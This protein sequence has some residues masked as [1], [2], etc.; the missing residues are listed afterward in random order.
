MAYIAG[1]FDGEGS[2][3]FVW[4]KA[5]NGK[6]YG[7]LFAKIAQN[8]RR[9]LDWVRRVLG[10]GAVYA[11]KPRYKSKTVTHHFVVQSEK[12]R[13]FLD[14]VLPYLRV[15]HRQAIKVLRLDALHVKRRLPIAA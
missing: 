7:K 8:D 4:S 9:I 3:S 5:K 12:A 10:Y 13:L 1:F 14:L 2:A 11:D 6:R 15:K